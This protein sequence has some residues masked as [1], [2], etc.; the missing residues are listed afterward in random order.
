[1][2]SDAVL[3][4]TDDNFEQEVVSSDLPVLVDFWA[5]WCMPCRM[6]APVI[7]EL[8]GEFA[9][10][11]KVGKV[12]TD[13]SREVSVKYGI[14][15]IPTIILFNKGEVVRKFVGVTPKSDFAEELSK[16]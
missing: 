3:E 7:D 9:G 5:E 8:A 15:A 16:Y 4:L 13:D 11:V 14:S 1:M 6:L 10:K 2:A 12:N